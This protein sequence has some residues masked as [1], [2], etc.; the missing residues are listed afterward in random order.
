MIRNIKIKAE[1]KHCNEWI[2]ICEMRPL[3]IKRIS[4]FNWTL[5]YQ[6]MVRIN[7]WNVWTCQQFSPFCPDL[8]RNFIINLGCSHNA[9]EKRT[10]KKPTGKIEE[11]DA[12]ANSHSFVFFYLLSML[13]FLSIVMMTCIWIKNQVPKLM[14]TCIMHAY[15][16]LDFKLPHDRHTNKILPPVFFPDE[17]K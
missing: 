12:R 7:P 16:M 5:T 2:C 1:E 3:R 9:S 13:K 8:F 15:Q 4:S 14:L 10:Q 11:S 6:K 17:W